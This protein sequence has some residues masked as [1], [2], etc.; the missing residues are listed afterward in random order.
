MIL[1]AARLSYTAPSPPV[2]ST[3]T[4]AKLHEQ[5]CPQT[6]QEDKA[7]L[8]TP[9]LRDTLKYI[10]NRCAFPEWHVQRTSPRLLNATL[11]PFLDRVTLGV[12]PPFSFPFADP[13]E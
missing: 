4:G 9:R 2:I 5:W 6:P 3:P 11:Y 8:P 1:F 7:S 12:I 13:W 10:Q